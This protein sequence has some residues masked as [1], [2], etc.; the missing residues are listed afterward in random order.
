MSVKTFKGTCGG[1]EGFCCGLVSKWGVGG[2]HQR[3][4]S[5]T[6]V[7]VLADKTLAH[8]VSVSVPTVGAMRGTAKRRK[9][10]PLKWGGGVKK[11]RLHRKV[12][13]TP[14]DSPKRQ[15]PL[16]CYRPQRFLC[17]VP[18]LAKP[19]KYSF[20]KNSLSCLQYSYLC[21]TYVSHIK[22]QREQSPFKTLY[23]LTVKPGSQSTARSCQ[24]A[25]RESVAM[26]IGQPLF[27]NNLII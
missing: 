26:L 2:Q 15:W 21:L 20:L 12:C 9:E 5:L 22:G 4:L 19:E 10:G 13:E 14:W 17:S 25:W 11:R 1:T 3:A 18:L 7:V 6:K 8:E 24:A 27:L 23:W 16:Q